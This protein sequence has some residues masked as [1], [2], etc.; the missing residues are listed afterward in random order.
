MLKDGQLEKIEMELA[1]RSRYASMPMASKLI[2]TIE[3]DSD[4]ALENFGSEQWGAGASKVI[5]QHYHSVLQGR[6]GQL[7]QS[8]E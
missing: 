3:E 8:G 2:R 5:A 7:G 1:N 4:D 6:T